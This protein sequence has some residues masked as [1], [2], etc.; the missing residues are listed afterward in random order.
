MTGAARSGTQIR[1]VIGKGGGEMTAVSENVVTTTFGVE[2][3]A[4]PHLSPRMI[5]SM[6]N[7]KYEGNEIACGLA[8]IPKGARILELGAGAGVVGAILARNIEGATILSVEANPTLIDHIAALHAHN[9]LG[10][11]IAVRH[12]VVLCNADAP[13]AIE[14]FV[15][16]NFLG[17]GLAQGNHPRAKGTSVPVI[18]YN[19]LKRDFPHDTIMM[20][21]E[22]GELDFLRDADLTG[23]D[24]IVA[25]FHRGIYGVPGMRQCKQAL[26]GKGFEMN[27]ELSKGTVKVWERRAADETAV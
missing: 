13:D 27:D 24:R 8:A 16:G 25:E 3:L 19:D 22:G 18:R 6:T 15:R 5:E 2:V 17:S 7:G 21:I 4:A 14:F 26:R 20:D 10:D 23:V 9:G 1:I 12:G 11:K